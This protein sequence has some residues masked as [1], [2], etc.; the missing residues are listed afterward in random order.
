MAGKI[1]IVEDNWDFREI[2]ATVLS[3]GG[4]EV[5]E[6]PGAQDGIQKAFS[7]SPDLII[8]DLGLPEMDGIEATTMLKRNPK[9]AD[10]PV[11][12]YTVWSDDFRARALEAGMVEFLP[13]TTPPQVLR[14][15]VG[16]FV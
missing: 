7:E 2:L 3:T 9:T 11:I 4:Y 12:A 8:M 10:I 1:L 14:D 5:I 16:R 15:I 6:A 13:K